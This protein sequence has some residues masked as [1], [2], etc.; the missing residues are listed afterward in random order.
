VKWKVNFLWVSFARDDWNF[1]IQMVEK[2]LSVP[3]MAGN[4]STGNVNTHNA[5]R[6]GKT[7]VNGNCVGNSIARIQYYSSCAACGVPGQ[8]S[9][10]RHNRL[11]QTG[12]LNVSL[13]LLTN[14]G[15]LALIQITQ[16]H[17]VI[18]KI[19]QQ[20]FLYLSLGWEVPLWVK[21]DVPQ[22]KFG[23]GHCW[24]IQHRWLLVSNFERT[25]SNGHFW[26]L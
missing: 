11:P 5:M 15:Q 18:Q 9:V 20:L 6:H 19:F 26:Y 14:W 21:Q 2:I 23:A 3:E 12:L 17:S 4:I 1:K 13:K 10:N 25:I 24:K 7:F 22:Q 8:T 16:A